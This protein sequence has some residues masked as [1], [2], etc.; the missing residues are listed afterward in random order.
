MQYSKSIN[1]LR[2]IFKREYN[3]PTKVIHIRS[4]IRNPS[5]N[6]WIGIKKK[7]ILTNI[8]LSQLPFR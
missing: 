3:N 4:V 7:M 5:L 6:L 1:I 2:S 8:T